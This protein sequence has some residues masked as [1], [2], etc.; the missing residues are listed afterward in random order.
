[1]SKEI[2]STNGEKL[3]EITLSKEVFG[4]EPNIHV[5]H[6]ALR[7]QLNNARQGNASAKT[8]AEVAGGGKKPWKQKGTGRARAGSLRSPLFRGGGVI[9]GPK[10]RSY[11]FAMPQKARKL[12]LKSA[13]S[14]KESQIVVVKDF[15]TISEPK[16][17]LMVSAL[18]SLNVS[19]KVLI[20][21]DTKAE[22]NKNLVLSARNI[23]SVKLLLPSNLNVKDL[24]EADFVV[25]TE[26]AVSEVTERLS[27]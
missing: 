10:P 20:V 16:T 4:V 23:P 19:G 26:S 27:K 2:L 15:S 6:L 8:R 1:M 17:K 21:A 9:F 3:G 13:L 5:M 18:K 24:L 7:R 14:A 12:A 25:M 22:E 11:A